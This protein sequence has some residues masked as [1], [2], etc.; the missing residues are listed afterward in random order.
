MQ[1][2]EIR[3]DGVRDG[4]AY[5]PPDFFGKTAGEAHAS[6]LGDDGRQQLPIAGFVIHTGGKR[7]LMGAG[8]GPMTV[9]WQPDDGPPIKLEGGRLLRRCPRRDWRPKISTSFCSAT[10]TLTTVDGY[11]TRTPLTSLTQRFVSGAEIGKLSSNRKCPVRTP[12]RSEPAPI[13]AK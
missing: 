12:P 5:L 2:G 11:G 10:G 8:M 4:T 1:L 9:E 7:V 13:S 6:I 3:I